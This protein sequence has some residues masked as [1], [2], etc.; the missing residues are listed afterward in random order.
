MTYHYEDDELTEE[1][2]RSFQFRG[3]DAA[4][5]VIRDRRSRHRDA[6]LVAAP[7]A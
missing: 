1:E 2:A 6:G 7:I 5:C 4:C 3:P